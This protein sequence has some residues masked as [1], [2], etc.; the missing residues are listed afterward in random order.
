MQLGSRPTVEFRHCTGNDRARSRYLH[1]SMKHS[2]RKT[3]AG[4][5]QA[6]RTPF[7]EEGGFVNWNGVVQVI[8]GAAVLLMAGSFPAASQGIPQ[9]TPASAVRSEER[10]VGKECRCRWAAEQ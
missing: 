1:V 5:V 9:P 8:A 3:L 6:G 7:R 10:R 2:G 4:V